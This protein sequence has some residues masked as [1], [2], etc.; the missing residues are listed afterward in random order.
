MARAGP[1]SEIWGSNKGGGDIKDQKLILRN[2]KKE[3]SYRRKSARISK[4]RFM[5][6]HE[7]SSEE[8]EV[9]S[10]NLVHIKEAP[11][12]F[13]PVIETIFTRKIM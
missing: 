6:E 10:E 7:S 1:I 9:E 5:P 13:S 8:E 11:K 12:I 2:P 3:M 4:I